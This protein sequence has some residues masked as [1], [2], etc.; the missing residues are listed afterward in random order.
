MAERYQVL[1]IGGGPGGYVAALRASQLGARVALV[2]ETYIG[3]VCLNVGC[4]PTKALLRSAEV[5]DEVRSAREFGLQVEGAVVPDWSAIQKRKER[6]VRL[7]TRGVEGLLKKAGVAVYDGRGRFVSLSAAGVHAVEVTNEGVQQRLE[8]EKVIVATGARPIRLPLPGFDLPGVLDSTGVLALEALPQ[9]LLIV[10]GG[11]IGCEF[12]ALYATLGVQV[13]VVEMLDRLLPMM[14]ADVSTEITRAFRKLKI[15]SHLGSRATG[16]EATGEALGVSV[17]TPEGARTFEVE[18]VLVSVGR[19]ANV[20]DLGLETV[21]V[22]VE[23][24]VV[25]DERM[26]TVVP[27]IYAIGDV[28]AKWWLAHVASH[29]GIVAAE[30]ACGHPASMNY[31]SVPACVFTRPEVASVGLTEAQAREQGYDVLIGK[32]PFA[33]VA[34]A[35]IYGQRQGFVKVV[36]ESRYGEV[37]GLHIVGPHASDLILEGGLALSMEATLDEI[38]ATVHAHPTLGESI[39]EAV[40]AARGRALHV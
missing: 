15:E 6:I 27:G 32:F 37:L 39:A 34:K 3:G 35:S 9:R 13:T 17:D 33:A 38:E 36:S 7:H 5:Y 20:E 29:E 19:R 10:G 16:I 18:T 26:Q 21:G 31:K 30:N 2:E 28:T 14:D 1:V 24:G 25:V 40:L 11:V 22:Q 12:A 23:R 8:A 4:I